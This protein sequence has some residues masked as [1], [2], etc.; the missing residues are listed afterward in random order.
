MQAALLAWGHYRS[1]ERPANR[2]RVPALSPVGM[3]GWKQ[4]H[5]SGE[6]TLVDLDQRCSERELLG[7]RQGAIMDGVPK[8]VEVRWWSP[9]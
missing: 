9:S 8:F 1:L 6:P 4:P 5:E 2:N 3:D 7:S